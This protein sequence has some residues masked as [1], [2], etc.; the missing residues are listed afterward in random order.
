MSGMEIPRH[1]W[2]KFLDDFSRKYHGWLTRAEQHGADSGA[3]VENYEL[4]LE[5]M[6]I[7]LKGKQEVLS[8]VLQKPDLPHGH[9]L[10]SIEGVTSITLEE[11]DN[12]GD[13]ILHIHS[14]DGRITV[15]R[16][17]RMVVPDR[18]PP[19]PGSSIQP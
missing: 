2:P 11:S 16:F 12:G 10:H 4:P 8:L 7:H 13:K 5:G 6:T 18:V 1:E 9:L 19:R 15:I 17:V 3:L 14:T